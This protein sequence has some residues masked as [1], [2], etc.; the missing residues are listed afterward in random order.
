MS[1]A[2]C[3]RRQVLSNAL[4]TIHSKLMS[5]GIAKE[6]P[7]EHCQF[8]AQCPAA[9]LWFTHHSADNLSFGGP[10]LHELQL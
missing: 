2:L 6:L 5:Q 7:L 8:P 1:A 9:S 10:W 4:V 3:L